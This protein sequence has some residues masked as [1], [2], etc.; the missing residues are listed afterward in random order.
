MR[1]NQEV[2]LVSKTAPCHGMRADPSLLHFFP[3][4]LSP[5]LVNEL[6]QDLSS[7]T[8][9][10]TWHSYLKIVKDLSWLIIEESARML[11]IIQVRLGVLPYS[12]W[13]PLG[14]IFN[15]PKIIFTI[16]C[17]WI[18]SLKV[19]A[20]LKLNK[21]KAFTMLVLFLYSVAPSNSVPPHASQ[22]LDR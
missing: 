12:S 9:L 11:L 21:Y 20:C 4:F 19:V 13:A 16:K 22:V 6:L 3:S 17:M 2:L 18:L 8:T 15:T 14:M 7:P 10:V 1:N 5:S